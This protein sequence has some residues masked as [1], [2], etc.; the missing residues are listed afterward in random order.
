MSI[1]T[2]GITHPAWCG[3]VGC[4]R[5]TAGEVEHH[6]VPRAV[7]AMFPEDD[8]P[9]ALGLVQT[10]ELCADGGQVPDE[11]RGAITLGPLVTHL[12][13]DQL[14][15]LAATAAELAA[16]VRGE[17]GAIARVTNPGSNP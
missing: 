3:Q 1:D 16:V 5:E 8:Q 13:A 9:L 6:E 4:E 2:S 11:P 10:D 17:S 12:R 7:F 14:D 15:A